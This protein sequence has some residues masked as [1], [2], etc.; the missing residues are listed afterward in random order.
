MKINLPKKT[1]IVFLLKIM[2]N[3]FAKKNNNCFADAKRAGGEACPSWERVG[4][5]DTNAAQKSVAYAAAVAAFL[6]AAVTSAVAFLT[7]AEASSVAD[8]PAAI[9]NSTVSI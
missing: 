5:E 2:Q 4:R 6:A 9:I 1:I 3:N 8:L 7:A